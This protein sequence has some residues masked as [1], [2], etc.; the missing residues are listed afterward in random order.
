[1]NG[2]DYMVTIMIEIWNYYQ[3]GGTMADRWCIGFVYWC[4]VMIGWVD[5]GSASLSSPSI[6]SINR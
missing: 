1:M 4:V 3:Y 6:T 5:D 2:G